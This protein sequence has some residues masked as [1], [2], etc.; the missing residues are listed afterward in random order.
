MKLMLKP[1]EIILM[2]GSSNLR[3]N[4]RHI[5]GKLI[6]TNQ[7]IYFRTLKQEYQF[8]NRE[9][10]PEDISELFYFNV[11]MILPRGIKIKTK[12]GEELDFTVRNRGEWAKLITKMF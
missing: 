3:H 10:H 9:I 1:N 7:R 4:D 5:N 11:M 2:A 6:V 8:C 12:T